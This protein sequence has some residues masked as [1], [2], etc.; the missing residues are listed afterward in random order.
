MKKNLIFIILTLFSLT[1]FAGTGK[2]NEVKLKIQSKNKVTIKQD[3]QRNKTS[4]KDDFTIFSNQLKLETTYSFFTLGLRKTALVFSGKEKD[5]TMPNFDYQYSNELFNHGW[6][7][8]LDRIYFKTKMK[9][10]S[11]I[12]GDFYESMNRGLIFSFKNDPAFGDNTIRGTDFKMRLK[13]FHFKA[14]GGKANPQVRDISLDERLNETDD[15]VW[16]TEVGYKLWKIDLSAQYGGGN[17]GD[18]TILEKKTLGNTTQGENISKSFHIIG[19]SLKINNA[20]PKSRLYATFNYIPKGEDDYNKIDIMKIGKKELNQSKEKKSDLD[21]SKAIFA[22]ISKWF[23]FSKN[24]LTLTTEGKMYDKYFLNYTLMEDSNYKRRYFNP[25]TLLWQNMPIANEFDTWAVREKIAFRDNFLTKADYSIEFV[26]GNSLNNEKSL[27]TTANYGRYVKE[28]FYFGGITLSK[29]FSSFYIN[30]KYGYY[31]I[32]TESDKDYTRWHYFYFETGSHYEKISGKLENSL[33]LKRFK[34]N[35]VEEQKGAIEDTVLLYIA[36]GQHLG[37]S[38]INTYWHN[39]VKD[40]L[41]NFY[42]SG[43]ISFKYKAVTTSLFYG[44]IKGGWVCEGTCR[45]VPD[46]QGFKLELNIDI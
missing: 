18:Y 29:Q 14:F 1:I 45:L 12:L 17:F 8:Y 40:G 3:F 41:D 15:Y 20:I 35:G 30:K 7:N 36:Y 39:D 21:G 25:P 34:N 26:K 2:K 5:D 23:D 42:P 22:T 32:N 28:D 11:L 37:F 19:T 10:F 13:G 31:Q 44:K 33:Y 9:H 16:G 43:K 38:F 6:Q 4:K 24:R 46:F 27:I